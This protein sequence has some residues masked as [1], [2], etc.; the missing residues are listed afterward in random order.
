MKISANANIYFKTYFIGIFLFDLP[1][2]SHLNTTVRWRLAFFPV[3]MYT[4][5]IILNVN[6]VIFIK[7]C[8]VIFIIH[9][10]ENYSNFT[11]STQIITRICNDVSKTSVYVSKTSIQIMSITVCKF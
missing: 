2:K 5:L 6:L 3:Y 4:K 7:V 11:V 10:T 1:L 8:Y 9:I